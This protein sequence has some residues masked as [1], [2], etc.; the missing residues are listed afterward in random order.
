MLELFYWAPLLL[1]VVY[2]ANFARLAVV[3]S[4]FAASF[5]GLFLAVMCLFYHAALADSYATL[6][7]NL[8]QAWAVTLADTIT[9]YNISLFYQPE[10]SSAGL[11]F[12]LSAAV[13]VP[14]FLTLLASKPFSVLQQ[15]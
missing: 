11:S 4:A 7:A 15:A 13:T 14:V 9:L 1:A 5:S 10:P 3:S 2:L 12:F 8:E 6:T